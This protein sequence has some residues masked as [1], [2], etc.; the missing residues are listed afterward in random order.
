MKRLTYIIT[1][2][3]IVW[4]P[5][6]ESRS[7]SHVVNT[8]FSV[9]FPVGKTVLDTAYTSNGS[10][11]SAMLDYLSAVRRDSSLSLLNVQITGMA[12][13]EGSYQT[14]R[15][16]ANRRAQALASWLR[17]HTDTELPLVLA[18]NMGVGWSLLDTLTLDSP[19]LSPYTASMAHI[20]SLDSTQ[21]S[22][23]RGLTIDRR[24]LLLRR[25]QGGRFWPILMRD[26][27]PQMR[28]ARAEVD[29]ARVETPPTIVCPAPE[30]MPEPA[31][32]T[33]TVAPSTADTVATTAET[34]CQ[35]HIILKTNAVAWAFLISNVAIEMD[36]APHWSVA[37]PVNFSAWNY[38]SNSRKYRIFSLYPE[39]RY[40]PSACNTGFFVGAH[41]GMAY[42]NV[43]FGGRYRTQD[44]G[45]YRPALGGGMSAGLRLPVSRNRRWQMELS[46]GVGVY[47]LNHDKFYNQPNGLKAYTENKTYTGIDQASL[48]LCYVFDFKRGRK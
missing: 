40:W 32:A 9:F 46:A 3:L 39:C 30:P 22:Y 15:R 43:A 10:S 14:N 26:V 19:R 31:P 17:A 18:D 33:P 36:V 35:R 47:S 42:Y 41:L 1:L 29:V 16:L 37:L 5:V 38:F 20:L 2:M 8:H 44:R 21:V 23:H 6:T 7:Q 13:P 28:M 45:G 25:A 4:M 24:V 48:S 12:S 11:L 34:P 27:Y